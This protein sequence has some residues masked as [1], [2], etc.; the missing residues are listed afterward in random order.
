MRVMEYI[1]DM[2][3]VLMLGTMEMLMERLSPKPSR[4]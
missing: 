4:S 1:F 3:S 2:K